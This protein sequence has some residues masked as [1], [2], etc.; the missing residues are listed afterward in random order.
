MV[1][2]CLRLV[3]HGVIFRIILFGHFHCHSAPRTLRES[4]S[5]DE[6]FEIFWCAWNRVVGNVFAR[7]SNRLLNCYLGLGCWR[8]RPSFRTGWCASW[9]LSPRKMQ[10]TDSN[11]WCSEWHWHDWQVLFLSDSSIRA[12]FQ[13]SCKRRAQPGSQCPRQKTWTNGPKSGEKHMFVFFKY[14]FL[15]AWNHVRLR[16]LGNFWHWIV[17]NLCQV[18]DK[19]SH[20]PS[21]FWFFFWCR[22]GKILQNLALQIE[23]ICSLHIL[24]TRWPCSWSQ[25][26]SSWDAD[27]SADQNQDNWTRFL[28]IAALWEH[29][30]SRLNW[31]RTVPIRAYPFGLIPF[32]IH[33]V[34]VSDAASMA[35]DVLPTIKPAQWCA[36]QLY[37]LQ[38]CCVAE[39][40]QSRF[41]ETPS[42]GAKE[43]SKHTS[44]SM[45]VLTCFNMLQPGFAWFCS[46][47]PAPKGSTSL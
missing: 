22:T 20:Q 10:R 27:G 37:F 44:V 21:F 41:A 29:F 39:L 24:H 30:F 16:Q 28:H 9:F 46:F 43:A 33:Q 26:E 14:W 11:G 3:C 25:A 31:N 15:I 8:S 6:G 40:A 32:D 13:H 23:N 45:H 7:V 1:S 4:I 36:A 19:K 18:G 42:A 34:Q 17:L 2:P 47:A 12:R 5:K 35:D 38:I